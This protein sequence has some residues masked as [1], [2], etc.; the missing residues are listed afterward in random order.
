[1]A[2]VIAQEMMTFRLG[3][4]IDVTCI[5]IGFAGALEIDGMLE[6]FLYGAAYGIF[7]TQEDHYRT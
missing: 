4:L 5:V 2:P 7:N 1:M 6:R 3:W